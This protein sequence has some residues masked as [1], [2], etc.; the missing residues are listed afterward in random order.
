MQFLDDSLLPEN[1]EKLVIQVAP[2]GPQFLPSDSDDIAVSMDAQIQKAVDCYNAG[3][4]V[5]HVHVREEDGKGSKRLSKFN[6]MLARLREAVPDMVLQVGGSISFAPEGEGEAAKW[7]NDDTRH[8]LAALTPTPDQVTIAINTN[9]MN[10]TELLTAEDCG[11]TSMGH[12]A[13]FQAYKEMWIPSGPAFV[14]EHLK[15]LQAAGIQPHFMLG[16]VGQLETVERLIRR[17]HYTGP[18]VLNWVAIGGGADG[19]NPRNL[20]EFINRCPQNT[21]LTVESLMRHVLPLNTMAIAMGLHVRVGI[22]DNLWGRAGERMTSVQQVEQMVRVARELHRD[23]A[24]GEDARRI[25]RIGEHY[26]SVDETLD[27]LG[28]RPNRRPGQRGFQI[29]A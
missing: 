24:S 28:Y 8:M 22:E 3:A 26:G 13:Y 19:P 16:D 17:G 10:V 11:D 15:R 20:M 27:A 18:L 29:A 6:E 9:Q 25:Y 4:T 1:Q 2:Y 23:V 7:L 21:V 14:E 5:L 12:P